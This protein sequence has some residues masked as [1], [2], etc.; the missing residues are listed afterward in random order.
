MLTSNRLIIK[1][2]SH[3]IENVILT[4]AKEENNETHSASTCCIPDC[5]EVLL[6]VT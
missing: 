2:L 5:T 4:V 6:L 1:K 3:S